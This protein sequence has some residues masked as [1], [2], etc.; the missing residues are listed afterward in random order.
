MIRA[1]V[2][3]VATFAGWVLAQPACA[4]YPLDVA[5]S[6]LTLPRVEDREIDRALRSPKTVFYKLPQVYQH[7]IPFSRVEIKNPV[8]G[9]LQYSFQKPVFGI[10]P[11]S[12]LADFNA[13]ADF[14]WE[15]TIGLNAAKKAKSDLYNTVNFISLPEDDI[16]GKLKPILL[17]T[18]E[19]PIKWVFP[20]G[21]IAGEVIYVTHERKRYIQEVRTRKKT[22][23]NAKWIPGV[24]RP[25][26]DR[27]EFQRLTGLRYVANKKF[28]LF[29]NPE[30]DE[31][32]RLEGTVEQLPDVPANVTRALLSRP[33][34]DVTKENWAP[35]AGQD[36]AI[37]PKDYS[38]GLLNPDTLVCAGCHRQT[39]ISVRN[40]IP[41]EK[42]IV[43]NP[44]K[45]GNIRGC[46]GIFTWYPFDA[47]SVGR[48]SGSI[49]VR[50]H[51]L[52]KG[53]V[54]FAQRGQVPPDYKLTLYVQQALKDYELPS[55]GVLHEIDG[56]KPKDKEPQPP[57]LRQV[58]VAEAYTW[59]YRDDLD[60]SKYFRGV[61]MH[62]GRMIGG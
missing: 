13:N 2:I 35:A 5:G 4:Q 42:L 23:D 36:F 19:R 18:D 57:D 11:A 3:L 25:V 50:S 48:D 31:V 49:H 8:L 22:D 47:Q 26:R 24:F 9:T 6:G 14:P 43:N 20:S 40:L 28:M 1:I 41:N 59:E 56:K 32:F 38:F 39:Q 10:H 12:Y 44:D 54:Q 52:Q 61:L 16:T 21:T 51:D 15:A 34:Q 60:A 30:E 58:V 45:V 53:I 37:T 29:R 55:A 17:L 46:D 27:E 33:F 62:D 7:Y